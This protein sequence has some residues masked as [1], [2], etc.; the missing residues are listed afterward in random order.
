MSA[1]HTFDPGKDKRVYVGH[2]IGPRFYREVLPEHYMVKYKGYGLQT[3]VVERLQEQKV[4][5]VYLREI[6]SGDT[7][8]S[9]IEDWRGPASIKATWGHGPQYFLPVEHM[10]RIK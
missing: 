4:R 1:I 9:N 10:R 3:D 7:L 8:I 6:S 5:E 2:T